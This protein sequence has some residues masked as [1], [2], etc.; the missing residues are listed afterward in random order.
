[1]LCRISAACGLT[2]EPTDILADPVD[3]VFPCAP[4]ACHRILASQWNVVN[5]VMYLGPQPHGDLRS[6]ISL[7]IFPRHVVYILARL[8]FVRTVV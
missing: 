8:Y 5:L 6:L 4:G 2:V 1:M 3:S 7:L